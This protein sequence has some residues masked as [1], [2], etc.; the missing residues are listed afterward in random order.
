MVDRES[1]VHML[2][3]SLAWTALFELS[4][5]WREMELGAGSAVVTRFLEEYY[6]WLDE[7]LAR[8]LFRAGV[9]DIYTYARAWL[10]QGNLNKEV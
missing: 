2:D 6:A 7:K 3:R 10:A 8:D 5:E 4:P 9:H 1:P